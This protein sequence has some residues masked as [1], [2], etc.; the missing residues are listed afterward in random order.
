MWALHFV[1]QPRIQRSLN[2]FVEMWNSHKLSS[3]RGKTPD[4]LFVQGALS[5]FRHDTP[6]INAIFGEDMKNG[7]GVDWNGPIVPTAESNNVTVVL[8]N[9]R[10]SMVDYLQLQLEVDPLSDIHNDHGISHFLN[11][12]DRRAAQLYIYISMPFISC[13]VVHH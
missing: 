6:A 7:Y 4:Q 1:Y 2:S 3:E 11:N 8:T 13:T 9:S 12:V 10:I 5:L